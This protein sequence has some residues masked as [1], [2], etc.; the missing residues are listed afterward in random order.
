MTA[1]TEVRRLTEVLSS[2]PH[3][4]T[5]HIERMQDADLPAE[6]LLAKV[7]TAAWEPSGG[8]SRSRGSK[9]ATWAPT[10]AGSTHSVAFDTPCSSR[11]P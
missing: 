4:A 3:D 2:D 6:T 10:L 9:T 1:A 11:R 8:T 5:G 7:V